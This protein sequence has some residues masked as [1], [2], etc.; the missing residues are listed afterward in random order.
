MCMP[1]IGNWLKIVVVPQSKLSH[2]GVSEFRP[3][4]MP[5]SLVLL[6]TLLGCTA[7]APK[8]VPGRPAADAMATLA[9][10]VARSA[11]NASSTAPADLP[12]IAASLADMLAAAGGDSSADFMPSPDI[13]GLPIDP[14]TNMPAFTVGLA[15]SFG[16]MPGSWNPLAPWSN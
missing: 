13:W 16:D 12:T 2:R 15:S 11:A 6:L 8:K 14:G 10:C 1:M 3:Y 5:L 9:D 7:A 4:A